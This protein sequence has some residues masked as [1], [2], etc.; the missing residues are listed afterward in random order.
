MTHREP[1]NAMKRAGGSNSKTAPIRQEKKTSDQNGEKL[2]W[3][4]KDG[5]WWAF[6]SDGYLKRG[7]GTG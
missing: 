4:Q 6:G 5:K 7:M 1:G 2:G 3:I